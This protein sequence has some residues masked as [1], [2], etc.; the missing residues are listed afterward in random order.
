VSVLFQ[1]GRSPIPQFDVF[2]LK[3]GRNYYFRITAKSKRGVEFELMTKGKIDLNNATA[4][5]T[6]TK[7]MKSNHRVLSG[8]PI[9]LRCEVEHHFILSFETTIYL[10]IFVHS[11]LVNQSQ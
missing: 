7:E 5:P 1:V 2:N 9:T 3:P 11:L 4:I 8:S 10:N 6:F